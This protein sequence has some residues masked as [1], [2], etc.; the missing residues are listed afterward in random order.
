M[1]NTHRSENAHIAKINLFIQK[2]PQQAQ[3]AIQDKWKHIER[4]RAD[5][6]NYVNISYLRKQHRMNIKQNKINSN[7]EKLTKYVFYLTI[8]TAILTII[9]IIV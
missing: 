1:R 5:R 6:E 3:T 8:F 7:M 2:N 9:Q 4:N